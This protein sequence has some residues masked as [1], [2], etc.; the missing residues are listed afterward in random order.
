[1]SYFRRLYKTFI[2]DVKSNNV[3]RACLSVGRPIDAILM[4]LSGKST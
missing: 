4:V 2:P 1:M 3:S